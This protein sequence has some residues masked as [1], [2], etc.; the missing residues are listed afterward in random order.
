MFS[1]TYLARPYPRR[2]WRAGAAREWAAHDHQ[3]GDV[4]DDED[5]E[6]GAH[7]DGLVDADVILGLDFS[8]STPEML[9]KV[10]LAEDA[11]ERPLQVATA[12]L[13]TC[14]LRHERQLR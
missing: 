4:A 13:I 1:I 8:L 6:C 2:A 7:V 10:D 5:E 12:G 14:V 9:P 11:E 3:D